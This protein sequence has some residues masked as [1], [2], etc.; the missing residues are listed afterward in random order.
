MIMIE[1]TDYCCETCLHT[2]TTSQICEK[3]RDNDM[4]EPYFNKCDGC[5]GAS[6]NDCEDCNKE[7]TCSRE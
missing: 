1:D 3:C 5:M 4:C 7:E 2:H 6:M